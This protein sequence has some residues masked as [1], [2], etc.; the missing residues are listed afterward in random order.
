M[1]QIAISLPDDKIEFIQRECETTGETYSEVINRVLRYFIGQRENSPNSGGYD[2]WPE[3]K[4]EMAWI[5]AAQRG[6]WAEC[7][8]EGEIPDLSEEKSG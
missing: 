8:W 3:T 7:P 5:E 2:L 4:E 1:G 6:V